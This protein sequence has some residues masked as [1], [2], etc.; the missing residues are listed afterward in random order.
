MGP[1]VC[2]DPAGVP[3]PGH[4]RRP[5]AGAGRA[6]QGRRPRPAHPSV[7]AHRPGKHGSRAANPGPAGGVGEH[8]DRAAGLQ[9]DHREDDDRLRSG[10]T[11]VDH[12]H[13][14]VRADGVDRRARPPLRGDLSDPRRLG[15]GDL[16]R[17]FVRARPGRRRLGG[18]RVR[19][20]IPTGGDGPVRWLETQ[21]PQPPARHSYR[22][23]RDWD[24]LRQRLET[25]GPA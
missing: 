19:P 16:R 15:G 25:G 13:G 14:A 6:G 8:A 11:V 17:R 5:G 24:Y 21:A 2:A 1:D 9:R 10:G 3:R 20:F 7:R 22:F 12:V 18:R 4:L 23:A